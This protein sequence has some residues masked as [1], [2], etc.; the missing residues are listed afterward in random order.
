MSA[1]G[2]LDIITDMLTDGSL[3]PSEILK[4]I[5]KMIIESGG[6]PIKGVRFNQTL[7][8]FDADVKFK[9]SEFVTQ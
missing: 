2:M 3:P 4:D 8:Y 5:A 1:D 6:Q 9:P 7:R